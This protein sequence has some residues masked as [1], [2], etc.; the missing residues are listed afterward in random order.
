VLDRGKR[1]SA[2]WPFVGV[3][4]QLLDVLAH[5]IA[6]A[7]TWRFLRGPVVAPDRIEDTRAPAPASERDLR[8]TELELVGV[9]ERSASFELAAIGNDNVA[10]LCAHEIGR[11]FVAHRDDEL[12]KLEAGDPDR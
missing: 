8:T 2:A 7:G 10:G 5:L 12:D 11:V 6:R 9:D 3:E 1:G 4:A